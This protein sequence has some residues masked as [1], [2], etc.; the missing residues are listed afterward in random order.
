[1]EQN[2]LIKVITDKNRIDIKIRY[3]IDILNVL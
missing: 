1:M 2:K 3:Q